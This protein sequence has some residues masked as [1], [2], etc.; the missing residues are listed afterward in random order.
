MLVKAKKIERE[1]ASVASSK[2]SQNQPTT[3]LLIGLSPISTA[4]C[5][6]VWQVGVPGSI[7]APALHYA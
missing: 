3:A 2:N 5:V 1:N 7:P 4:G 6:L